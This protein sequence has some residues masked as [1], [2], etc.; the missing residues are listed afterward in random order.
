M[1][2]GLLVSL[3]GQ[4][5][6]QRRLDTLANNVA[7]AGTS[8][9]RAENVTFESTISRDAVAYARAGGATYSPAAGPLTQTDSPLDVAVHGDA[10]LAVSTPQGIAYTRDGRLRISATGT[11]ETMQGYALLDQGAAPIQVNPAAGPVQIARNGGVSQSGVPVGTIGLFRLPADARLGRG[12]AN[13]LLSDRTGDPIADFGKA[14]L[15]QGFVEGSNVNSILELTK[16]MMVTRSFEA[17]S[18][19][20]EQGDRKLSDTIRTLGTGLK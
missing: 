11:L 2:Q 10:Y 6:L 19:S 13:T 17:L 7:N 16:L 4:L 9:F 18:A 8:G 15:A 14:G 12:P 1:E 3:S 20:I 5:A